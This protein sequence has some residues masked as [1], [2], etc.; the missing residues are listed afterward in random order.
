MYKKLIALA[1]QLDA[2]NLHNE[3][4][5]IDTILREAYF[6]PTDSV[7]GTPVVFQDGQYEKI[8]DKEDYQPLPW[9]AREEE[10]KRQLAK[11]PLDRLRDLF[12]GVKSFVLGGA[13]L[14]KF[15][16]AAGQEVVENDAQLKMITT[17]LEEGKIEEVIKTL[18]S[19]P[20]S[21]GQFILNLIKDVA[22]TKMPSK[23]EASLS[24]K[25]NPTE[26]QPLR[27][28]V[29]TDG[30]GGITLANEGEPTQ[31][32]LMIAKMIPPGNQLLLDPNV[33]TPSA[34]TND[35][36]KAYFDFNDTNSSTYELVKPAQMK[37]DGKQGVVES[38]GVINF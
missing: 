4:S 14:R 36:L 32:Y 10:L 27:V 16:F 33:K 26:D 9:E 18:A 19:L 13:E 3:A 11:Q 7:G 28:N 34:A 12:E 6:R 30:R 5:I 20:K 2:K 29:K 37:W 22:K 21:I 17:L 31:V 15:T 24:L 25:A 35:N 8:K 38:K 1:D 23:T